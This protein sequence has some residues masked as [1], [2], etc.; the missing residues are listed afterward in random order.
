MA[1]GE[2]H[3]LYNGS[4]AILSYLILC[5]LFW[6]KLTSLSYSDSHL[7]SHTAPP[8]MEL[9]TGLVNLFWAAELYLKPLGNADTSSSDQGSGNNNNNKKTSF[10]SEQNKMK[11]IYSFWQSIIKKI[12]A[13]DIDGFCLSWKWKHVP[14]LQWNQ[15]IPPASTRKLEWLPIALRVRLKLLSHA[16]GSG[17]STSPSHFPLLPFPV[18][19]LHP[20]SSRSSEDQFSSFLLNAIPF[21]CNN[22][23]LLLGPSL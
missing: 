6:G 4:R 7:F 16:L 13:G 12:M 5:L 8:H 2:S 22:P 23:E 18:F 19:H 3:T 10:F 11:I 20:P 14:L 21:T 15:T 9:C 1:L 17:P